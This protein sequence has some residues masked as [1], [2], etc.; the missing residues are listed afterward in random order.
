METVKLKKEFIIL[1]VI[2]AAL[3]VY[4]FQRSGDRTRY[5]LLAATGAHPAARLAFPP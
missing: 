4:L 3:T 5:R 1:G 2:I